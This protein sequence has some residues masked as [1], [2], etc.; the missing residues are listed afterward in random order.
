MHHIIPVLDYIFRSLIMIS[1]ENLM[2]NNVEINREKGQALVEMSISMILL[3]VLLAGLV[4]FGRAFFTYITLRDAA[5]EGA[6]YASIAE[7]EVLSSTSDVVAYC[8]AIENRARAT[9]SN[10]VDLTSGD[11]AVETTINGTDCASLS[12]S[13]VCMGGAVSVRVSH[14]NFP[15]TMPF[16]GTILGTQTL[17]LSAVVIDSILTPACQ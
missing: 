11:I 6:S 15:I 8:T 4:D 13:N 2:K 1:K 14:Q 10:P 16:L 3:L 12:A 9:S 7:P 17:P 5:Q